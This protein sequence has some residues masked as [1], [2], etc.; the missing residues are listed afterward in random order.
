MLALALSI[1]LSL[2]LSLSLFLLL[3]LCCSRTL[4]RS[5]VFAS[6]LFLSLPLSRAFV[7]ALSRAR[8]H[9][10]LAR[11]FSAHSCLLIIII[12]FVHS[13]YATIILVLIVLQIVC[14]HTLLLSC[15]CSHAFFLARTR[16]LPHTCSFRRVFVHRC[17][18]SYDRIPFALP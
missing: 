3:S 14:F 10:A 17:E 5:L 6:C 15:A 9:L 8:V 11:I 13:F 1:S 2:S 12:F 16:A 7:L 18:R 4:P